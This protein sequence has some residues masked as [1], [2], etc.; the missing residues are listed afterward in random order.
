MADSSMEDSSMSILASVSLRGE[1]IE[2]VPFQI[3][4]HRDAARKQSFDVD[5]I[6][7]DR[8]ERSRRREKF[9]LHRV[10]PR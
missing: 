5:D 10:T 6:N 3:P 8:V 7:S 1:E 2:F 4:R 9:F